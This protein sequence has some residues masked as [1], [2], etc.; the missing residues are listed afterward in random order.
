MHSDATTVEEY[1]QT[2]PPE[3]GEQLRQVLDEIRP[4]LP[5][6]LSEEM[7]YGMITWVVPLEREPDTYN[8][9][10][11]TYAALASQKQYMSLYLMTVYGGAM[12][13]EEFRARWSGPKKLNMGKSCVRFKD[14]S[15]LDFGLINEVL[16]AVSVDAFVDTNRELQADRKKR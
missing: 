11:L 7:S 1:L 14:V 4:H 12:T 10:P 13:E 6:G 3:R 8:G 5:E 16:D 2:I 9:R 15:E